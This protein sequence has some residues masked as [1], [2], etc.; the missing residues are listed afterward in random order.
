MVKI[1]QEKPKYIPNC[2]LANASS[3]LSIYPV[4]S[5]VGGKSI[6]VASY[7]AEGVSVKSK[8]QK[9]AMLF[10]HYLTQKDTLEKFYTEASKTRLFGEPYPRRDMADE[11]K[12]EPMIYPFISGLDNAGSSYFASDTHDGDT[13]LIR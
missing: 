3:D 12:N 7:W 6:T 5:I 11:L 2:P 1:S 13:G 8:N 9:E 4:P 10:M